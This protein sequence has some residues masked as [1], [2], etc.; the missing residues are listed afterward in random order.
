MPSRNSPA[1]LGNS[2]GRNMNR[3]GR[4]ITSAR[5]PRSQVFQS[6]DRVAVIAPSAIRICWSG[7]IRSLASPKAWRAKVPCSSSVRRTTRCGV[8]R[9]SRARRSPRR[10]LRSTAR[11]FRRAAGACSSHPTPKHHVRELPARRRRIQATAGVRAPRDAAPRPRRRGA[12][13]DPARHNLD[14]SRHPV[15]P[16]L[17]TCAE[18]R[19]RDGAA[20]RHAGGEKADGAAAPTR[21]CNAA[22]ARRRLK[23][24]PECGRRAGSNRTESHGRRPWSTPRRGSAS[25]RCGRD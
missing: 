14:P 3:P 20:A 18:P 12:S 16:N 4:R 10:P 19:Q 8:Q 17:V 15:D 21:R 23:R 24:R 22:A 7:R 1:R 11:R 13:K 6:S 25:P 9:L 2:S 5:L